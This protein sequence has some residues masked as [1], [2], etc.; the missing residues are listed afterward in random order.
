MKLSE[1]IYVRTLALL[2]ILLIA[3]LVVEFVV[4]VECD[5]NATKTETVVEHS[6]QRFQ[7]V[8]KDDNSALIVY[9]DTETNVMY[10]IRS[11]YGGACVMVDAEGEPLLWDGGATK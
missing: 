8:I 1:K 10:L 5:K 3:L 2:V 9:V 7:R 4:A 6:Q 11:I